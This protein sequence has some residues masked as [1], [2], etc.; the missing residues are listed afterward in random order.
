MAVQNGLLAS[1]GSL[2][3]PPA[4]FSIF[5]NSLG[6]LRGSFLGDQID[7]T[8]IGT[9]LHFLFRFAQDPFFIHL[10]PNPNINVMDDG[11]RNGDLTSL[12]LNNARS[13]YFFAAPPETDVA[14]QASSIAELAKEFLRK[15]ALD[16]EVIEFD[17]F[18]W[19]MGNMKPVRG[20]EALGYW[21]PFLISAYEYQ[22]WLREKREAEENGE[23]HTEPFPLLL[24]QNYQ[25][26]FRN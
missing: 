2:D 14:A 9:N 20:E 21:G 25:P 18:P 1:F 17:E 15:G 6:D 10:D 22:Q 8:G 23:E 7:L 16:A 5:A 24:D 12:H 11:I 4:R 13:I 3:A 26:Y 19:D